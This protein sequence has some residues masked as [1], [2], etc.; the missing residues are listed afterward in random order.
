MLRLGEKRKKIIAEVVILDE[1]LNEPSLANEYQNCEHSEV[2]GLQRLNQ[3]MMRAWF[4]F[5]KQSTQDLVGSLVRSEV[6]L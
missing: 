4:A 6:G 5:G 3:G 2:F 1:V